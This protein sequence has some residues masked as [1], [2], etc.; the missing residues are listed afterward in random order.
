LASYLF[1]RTTGWKPYRGGVFTFQFGR[2][3]VATGRGDLGTIGE[4][5]IDR[6][7]QVQDFIPSDGD[8]CVDVGAHIGC[9][10]LQWRLT[11]RTG[12]II[13]VE[14]HPRTVEVLRANC[15]LNPGADVTV[16]A[17]AVGS[18]EGPLEMILDANENRMALT[19]GDHLR[20]TGAFA[21]QQRHAVPG[22]TLDSLV[23]T[24]G[25][26]HVHLLKIDVEGYEVECLKGGAKTLGMTDRI[27]VEVHSTP[28]KT[29]CARIL[30]GHGFSFHIT[31]NLMFAKRM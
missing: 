28:L 16:V 13:A 10:A 22:I 20:Y 18:R 24:Q 12:R 31:G 1:Y 4:I 23:A 6:L 30:T 7:H 8:T 3:H 9:V 11:N 25:V 17:A 5:F 29:E 19:A 2:F 27:I 26:R 21:A 14:P 15:A